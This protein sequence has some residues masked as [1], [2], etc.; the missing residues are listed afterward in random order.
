M[1]NDN[2][3]RLRQREIMAMVRTYEDTI[4]NGGVCFFEVE[5]YNLIAD[6]YVR[7]DQYNK[8]VKL[9][10]QAIEQ[11]PFSSSLQIRKAHL[12]IDLNELQ[13]AKEL[14]DQA[15]IID[16]LEPE[17]FM[18]EARWAVA[19]GAFRHAEKIILEALHTL[20]PDDHID[21]L[22]ELVDLYDI[23]G[24]PHKTF[25]ALVELVKKDS[26]NQEVLNRFALCIEESQLYEESIKIHQAIIDEHPYNHFAW[27]NLGLA[28]AGMGLY[29]KAIDTYSYALAIKEDFEPSI[30]ET[31][32]AYYELE[33]Y[34]E[35]L[36]YFLQS[37]GLVK[38]H[39]EELYFSIG[40]THFH[41]KNYKKAQFY[42]TK[43]LK[44]DPS[45]G[46]VYYMLGEIERVNGHYHKA[47]AEYL[48]AIQVDEE[49]ADFLEAYAMLSYQ[50]NNY[51]TASDFLVRA[52]EAN[53]RNKKLW[54]TLA[55]CYYDLDYFSESFDV[56]Q[57]A[58]EILN[59]PNDLLYL[60]SLALYKLGR[61]Q[62]CLE[63]LNIALGRDFSIHEILFEWEEDLIE[64]EDIMLLIQQYKDKEDSDKE[65]VN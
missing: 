38:A 13:L 43:A 41:L 23:W 25:E 19:S 31:G 44:I 53:P 58:I 61:K 36:E 52:L 14:I 59:E 40:Y 47:L 24:K 39:D 16:G 56:L 17:T 22:F 32:E 5:S 7:T 57:K 37:A 55:K 28:Y 46:E 35:A 11:H 60:A 29:E 50:M 51:Q 20:P 2:N 49:N 12:H 65:N 6:Y 9:I 10:E 18:V 48:K 1:K 63:L 8:A 54:L 30:R 4:N 21:L 26:Q 45:Y 15:K 3:D 62:S 34:A 42:F 64:D 27:H 33:K